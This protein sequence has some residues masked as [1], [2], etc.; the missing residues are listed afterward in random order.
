MKLLDV[1]EDYQGEYILED[2]GEKWAISDYV[3]EFQLGSDEGDRGPEVICL[4][5]QDG[6][7]K[8]TRILS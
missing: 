2:G 4:P 7:L 8:L 6:S 3:T 5:G 1:L